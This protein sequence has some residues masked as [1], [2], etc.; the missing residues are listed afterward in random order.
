[1]GH[2]VIPLYDAAES[3]YVVPKGIGLGDG[4]RMPDAAAAAWP[5]LLPLEERHILRV[6]LRV[7]SGTHTSTTDHVII[8]YQLRSGGAGAGRGLVGLGR[9]RRRRRRPLAPN[10]RTYSSARAA[11]NLGNGITE[12]RRTHYYYV[13]L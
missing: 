11:A 9:R 2:I 13:L 7:H 8:G 3:E 1:M 4:E 5:T 10:A 6:V 12:E